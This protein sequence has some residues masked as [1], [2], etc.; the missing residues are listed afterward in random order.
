MDLEAERVRAM[1]HF[2]NLYE[3][4]VFGPE[5]ARHAVKQY[6]AAPGCPHPQIGHDVKTELERRAH[7]S[8]DAKVAE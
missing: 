2:A 4:P 7:G 6:L 3:W 8:R 1:T 5:Y